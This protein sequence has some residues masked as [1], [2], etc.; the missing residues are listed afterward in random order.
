M[1]NFPKKKLTKIIKNF[2]GK[3]IMVIG[4]F[5]LDK[6]IWGEVSRI[7]PEA[8]VPIINVTKQTYCLGGA[9][10]VAQNLVSAGVVPLPMGVFN[11]DEN[12]RQLLSLMQ[13]DNISTRN[14]IIDHS[15]SST[16]KTRIV[17]H[18]QQ[19]ARID[20]ENTE[21]VSIKIQKQIIKTV[22]DKIKEIDAIILSDYGKG[23]ITKGLIKELVKLS[24]KAG[25]FIAVDPK[26]THFMSY[27]NVSLITPNHHEAG[28]AIAHK[29]IDQKSLESVAHT[30]LK[31]LSL[32]GILITRGKKGMA[33][34]EKSPARL[35]L[36]P[37]VASQV[38][39]V[40]GAGDTV[41]SIFTAA[42]TAGAN[43]REAAYISNY[44]AGIVV[45]EMGTA[46]ITQKEL[47]NSL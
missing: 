11:N 6:Y 42:I 14:M 46:S 24:N 16:C 44:A 43:Y 47:I 19:V 34:L 7:S 25:K 32:Q 17:A 23:V 22:K 37:T 35:S 39:D 12:G 31:R 15:R 13:E 26:E 2:S 29:I 3:K 20:Y 45:R 27:K 36:F 40:T 5:M 9:A 41:I 21:P 1:V 30:L 28:N 18:Q 10:N 8:P 4:D 33:L 38:F